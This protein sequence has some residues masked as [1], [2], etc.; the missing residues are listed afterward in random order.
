M[1]RSGSARSCSLTRFSA[2]PRAGPPPTTSSQTSGPGSTRTGYSEVNQPTVRARS[3]PS[4]SSSRPCPSTSTSTAVCRPRASLRRHCATARPRAVSRT[5]STPAWK[6]VGTVV[7]SGVVTSGGRERVRSRARPTVSRTGSSRPTVSGGSAAVSRS[8][9]SVASAA[10]AGRRASAASSPAQR[11]SEVATGSSRGGRP[12]RTASQAAMRSGRRMR[13]DTPSTTRWL[14]RSSSLPG[15]T[16]PASNQT[17]WS[18]GPRSA[19]R[20]AVAAFTWSRTRASSMSTPPTS[21]TC[22]RSEAVTEPTGPT[23]SDHGP[24]PGPPGV[25]VSRSASW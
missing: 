11:R 8:V 15:R 3:T 21:R 6:A 22:T 14:T 23:S 1:P 12:C 17:V 25:R 13:Q 16:G 18:S 20:R 7:R 2:G 10:R 9:H 4:T 5:S 19:D 24:A